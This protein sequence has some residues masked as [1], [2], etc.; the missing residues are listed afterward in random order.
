MFRNLIMS[1]LILQHKLHTSHIENWKVQKDGTV[2]VVGKYPGNYPN[3]SI[4]TMTKNEA[5]RQYALMTCPSEGWEV[6]ISKKSWH[7][8]VEKQ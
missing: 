2:L 3:Q 6:I 7:T 4:H 8:F 5:L 1:D